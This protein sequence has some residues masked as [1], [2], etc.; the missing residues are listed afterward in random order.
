MANY[1]LC[2]V[3]KLYSSFGQVWD[4]DLFAVLSPDKTFK[5]LGCNNENY[6]HI[7]VWCFL[8]VFGGGFFVFFFKVFSPSST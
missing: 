8:F 2:F 1:L 6:A 7:A 5:S 3:Q 4:V